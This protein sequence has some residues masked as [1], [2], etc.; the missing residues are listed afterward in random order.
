MHPLQSGLIRR[1]VRQQR[2]PGLPREK[3]LWFAIRRV[4]EIFS[5]YVPALRFRLQL[6]TSRFDFW[7]TPWQD[8]E[9]RYCELPSVED[10]QLEGNQSYWIARWRPVGNYVM[11]AAS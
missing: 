10:A 1:K 8:L 3:L 5:T 9:L 6:E 4:R 7:N 11:L 2:R